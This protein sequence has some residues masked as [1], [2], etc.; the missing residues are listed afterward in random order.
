MLGGDNNDVYALG[1]WESV[2]Q[3]V[4]GAGNLGF[5]VGAYPVA[6]SVLTDLC[7]LGFNLGGKHVS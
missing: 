2:N 4:L 5:S 1:N 3:L 6:S 7:E